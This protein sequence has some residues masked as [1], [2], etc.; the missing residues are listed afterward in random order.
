MTDPNDFVR[1]A[2]LRYLQEIYL[3][4]TGSHRSETEDDRLT[5]DIR[6]RTGIAKALVVA[7]INYLADR[8]L[9]S[10]RRASSKD[11]AEC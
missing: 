3:D 4:H 10:Q 11:G 1:R 7:N 5:A 2:I 6:K 8:G 9:I